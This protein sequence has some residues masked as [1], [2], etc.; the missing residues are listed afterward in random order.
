VR[1]EGYAIDDEECSLGLRCVG[2]PVLDHRGTV[3]AA[4]SVVAPCHD[5]HPR[6]SQQ[7]SPQYARRRRRSRTA[8]ALRKHSPG[9]EV[10]QPMPVITIRMLEGRTLEQKREITKVV[11]EGG[12][13]DRQDTPRRRSRDLRGGAPG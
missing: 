4:L 8:L 2:A 3:V 6:R 9:E 10:R 7:R 5:S 13:A 1:D 12:V 11:S